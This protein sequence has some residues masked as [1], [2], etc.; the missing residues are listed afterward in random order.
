M[1]VIA[2]TTVMFHGTKSSL[3]DFTKGKKFFKQGRTM[4]ALLHLNSASAAEPDNGEILLYL[5]STY[6]KLGRKEDVLKTLEALHEIDGK[7]LEVNKWLAGAYYGKNEFAKAEKLYQESL[8]EKY[9]TNS[10]MKLAEVQAWQ[11]KY[12]KAV[13]TLEQMIKQNPNNV[14]ARKLLADI[15]IWNKK[16]DR[17]FDILTE[18]HEKYPQDNSISLQYAM[19][20]VERKDY[21]GAEELYRGI[22]ANDKNNAEAKLWLARLLSWEKEYDSALNIYTELIDANS[23]WITARREKARVLGWARRYEEAIAEYKKAVEAD[24][25]IPATKYEMLSKYN[26]Y[27]QFDKT[28]IENYKHWLDA[29]PNN[30]EASYDLGQVYAKQM[31]WD[32]AKKMY[33]LTLD[34]DGGHFRAKQAL[35][36]VNIYSNMMRLET[37]FKTF[38]ADSSGRNMDK[39]YRG[40]FTSIKKPLNEN[41]SVTI[42]QDN[43][44]RNFRD[45]KQVYQQQFSVGVDYSQKPDF[46]AGANYTGSVYPEEKG[47]AHTFG[48]YFN[49]MPADPLT[50][51]L[52][53]QREQITDNS[54][55]FLDKLYADN[56]KIRVDYKPTRRLAAGTDYTYSPYSDGNRKNAY[57]LDVGY[58]L[59]LEPKSLKISYKYEQYGF[60]DKD[61]DYFSP[62]SFH[63][64]N[65]ALEWRH[66]LNKEEMFWGANDTYYTLRYEIIFDVH[67]QTGHKFYFDFHHDWNN[68]C[69]SG[70][71]FSKTMY[72]HSGIYSEDMLMFY[73]SI[74][75]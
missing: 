13:I 37:G 11:K 30:L 39:R 35:E 7:D 59:A 48:G 46:W 67:Q 66:F 27:N 50:V 25:S 1:A 33:Q 34:N 5:A 45:Y 9:D 68:K 2:A 19:I 14:R 12:G 32:N 38:E 75:F 49:F 31:Q 64:N 40:I 28:A 16:Y 6:D 26:L 44:W 53:H 63:H 62:G 74:Y 57:G 72:E 17:A 8:A 70:I 41:T 73:T 22:L 43:I 52:S 61:G 58:Y 69:S 4:M 3:K 20:F 71:E 24:E 54:R 65:V 18:L 36:K 21:S 60:K 15:Y 47:L 29:E 56:Y 23:E 51:G 42:R 55:T 10:Q